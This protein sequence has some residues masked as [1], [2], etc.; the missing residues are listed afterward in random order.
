MFT[1]RQIGARQWLDLLRPHLIWPSF[2]CFLQ[3]QLMLPQH[4]ISSYIPFGNC[5]FL[6]HLNNKLQNENISNITEITK[7]TNLWCLHSVLFQLL[8][9]LLLLLLL[10][11]RFLWPHHRLLLRVWQIHFQRPFLLLEILLFLL[12][13]LVPS[14]PLLGSL[15]LSFL[16]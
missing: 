4:Q 2:H 13:N 12:G 5:L 7:P 10:K 11:H 15:L 1:L 9:H 6:L 14:F 8:H 3:A 16:G